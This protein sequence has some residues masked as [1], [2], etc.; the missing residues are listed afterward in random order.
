MLKMALVLNDER[1]SAAMDLAKL[2]ARNEKLE[3]KL[4]KAEIEL[5]NH[6]EKY[7]VFVEQT[8][9]LRETR[10]ALEKARRELQELE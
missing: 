3:G 1:G 8:T 7:K 6:Q 9:E 10:M 4:L 2:R 5:A